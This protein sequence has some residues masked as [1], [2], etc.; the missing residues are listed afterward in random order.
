MVR[1]ET[2]GYSSEER[3]LHGWQTDIG[4]CPETTPLQFFSS[5]YDEATGE[6]IVKVVNSEAQSYP[7]RIKLDGVDSVEKTGKVIS[8]SAASDMDENSFEEPMKI[9]PKES[10]YKRLWKELR[11]Y[12]PAILI[13]YIESEGEM[14]SIEALLMQYVIKSAFFLTYAVC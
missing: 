11:L 9:S 5:G 8:L 14:I 13:Y 1:R 2:G 7:L 10:E 4:P 6:V 12:L 3:T